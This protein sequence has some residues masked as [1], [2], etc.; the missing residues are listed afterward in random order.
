MKIPGTDDFAD[1]SRR[2]LADARALATAG[3]W[4]GVVHLAGF[5]AECALKASL[6][7]RQVSGFVGKDHGHD[8]D[9][10]AG[11]AWA[12]TSDVLGDSGL[13]YD[14]REVV[15]SALGAGHPDRRYWRRGWTKDEAEAEL[16]RAERLVR[17]AIVAR[18][19]DDGAPWG[20]D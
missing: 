3:R 4:D 16:D 7:R 13:R 15:G 19:L 17:N 11:W 2:H 1:A 10:L 8:L 5:A 12:W 9:A 18:V 6:E 20:D 14:V